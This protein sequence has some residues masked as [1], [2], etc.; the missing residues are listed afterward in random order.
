MNNLQSLPMLMK[1]E[2]GLH[3]H[4][5]QEAIGH[6]SLSHPFLL[7]R[8]HPDHPF[9]SFFSSHHIN[10]LSC[11]TRACDYLEPHLCLHKF[12]TSHLQQQQLEMVCLES[13]EG[14]T[15]FPHFDS[16]T[17][18]HSCSNVSPDRPSKIMIGVVLA[19][20]LQNTVMLFST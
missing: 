14:L 1:F 4:C 20:K 5:S 12:K 17:C 13:S 9:L 3:Q 7:P 19:S 6:N 11:G 10:F 18:I 16:C 2:V 8:Q 15:C